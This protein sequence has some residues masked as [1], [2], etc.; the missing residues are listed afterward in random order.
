MH[1]PTDASWTAKSRLARRLPN[2]EYVQDSEETAVMMVGDADLDAA[3]RER[4]KEMQAR[5]QRLTFEE[6]HENVAIIGTPERCIERI[7]W[8]REEFQ[9]EEFQLSESICWFNPGGLMPLQTVLTSMSRFAAHI[10]P[11]FR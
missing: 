9:L 8:L 3:M 10:M 2:G 11:I 7:Q 4:H 1:V 6:V 5:L